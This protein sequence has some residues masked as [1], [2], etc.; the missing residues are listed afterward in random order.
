MLYFFF[1]LD[2]T[3]TDSKP[4]ITRSVQY[5]LAKCGIEEPDL[6]KLEKF[7]GP[8]LFQSFQDFYGFSD[9][10]ATEAVALYRERY[11]SVGL[12]ENAPY[13]GIADLLEHLRHT[14]A[15]MVVASGKP[16]A[17]VEP[18]LEHFSLTSYFQL[19]A[20]STLD[21]R[22][23]TKEDVLADAMKTLG[24]TKNDIGV[25]IGDRK[26]DIRGA[27]AFGMYSI[28]VRYGYAP[29]GELEEAGADQIAETVDELGE[30]LSRMTNAQSADDI[31]AIM[32][33]RQ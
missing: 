31:E 13:P 5:A 32:H 29:V 30:V 3:L 6:D 26:Y 19:I 28:G 23:L 8:P 18:I 20:G 27:K 24:F 1:D 33:I 11:S 14:G 22:L 17:Y 12:F 7:I 25:M 4:G 10:Q 2:G 16:A 21:G 9:E 15:C